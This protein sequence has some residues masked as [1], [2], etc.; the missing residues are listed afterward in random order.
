M[1]L[2]SGLGRSENS[3]KPQATLQI[4]DNYLM[5][6]GTSLGREG[7]AAEPTWCTESSEGT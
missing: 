2:P 5:N 6:C 3:S 1:D 7:P 4:T